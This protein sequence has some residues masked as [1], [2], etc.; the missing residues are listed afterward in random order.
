MWRSH[1]WP[2]RCEV[3]P[4]EGT[5]CRPFSRLSGRDPINSQAEGP[6]HAA[7]DPH[8]GNTPIVPDVSAGAYPTR[9]RAPPGAW[10]RRRA[11]ALDATFCYSPLPPHPTAGEGSAPAARCCG[12]E[13]SGR[14]EYQRGGGDTAAHGGE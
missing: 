11:Q 8:T 12:P 7:T 13:P 5:V 2:T 4:L 3:S 1:R 6:H 10:T 14:D 9:G